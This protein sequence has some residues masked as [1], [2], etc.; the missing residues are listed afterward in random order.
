VLTAEI[1]F[2]PGLM[3]RQDVVFG[4]EYG[5]EVSTELTAVPVRV[6]PG[7][8]LP[9]PEGLRGWFTAGGEPVPAAAEEDGPGKVILVRVPGGN[10]VLDKLVSARR[11]PMLPTLQWQMRLGDEDRVRFLSLSSTPYK[12]SRVPSALFDI[13][14]ELGPADGGVFWFLTN[15]RLLK[16]PRGRAQR[17]ADAVAVAGLQAAADNRRRAVVLILGDGGVTD[18]SRYAPKVVREYLDSLRVPL[19][20]W[21][22]HG[23]QATAAKA[24]GGA[25]DVSTLDRMERAVARLRADL[26]S[27]RIV[28]LEGRHLPQSIDLTPAARGLELAR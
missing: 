16:E 9:A 17:I 22:L 3:A 1:W 26:A 18:S 25:E 12:T 6:R 2:P 24:W 8:A 15:R 21:S 28:W 13:S 14:R 7:A 10:E 23:P 5:S 4:G 27:Q 11:R 19:F 20:V